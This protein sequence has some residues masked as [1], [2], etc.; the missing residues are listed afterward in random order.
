MAALTTAWL[1]SVTA[2]SQARGGA[3]ACSP[4]SPAPCSASCSPVG[5][6]PAS[7]ALLPPAPA[8]GISGVPVGV[9]LGTGCGSLIAGLPL[10]PLPMLV[11]IPPARA[12]GAD[13]RLIDE[14]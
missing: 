6:G 1:A 3:S 7:P 11:L 5:C 4:E 12:G 14:A 2:R 13:A 9:E 10:A 8:A